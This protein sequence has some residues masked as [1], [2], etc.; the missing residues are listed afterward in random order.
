MGGGRWGWDLVKGDRRS[1]PGDKRHPG[2]TMTSG[3]M[4]PQVRGQGGSERRGIS[5][6]NSGSRKGFSQVN[7]YD[8]GRAGTKTM[9]YQ[10]MEGSSCPFEEACT[11]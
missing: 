2:G 8:R 6:Q 1:G 11:K 9:R 3:K 4:N 7:I 10:A 5:R